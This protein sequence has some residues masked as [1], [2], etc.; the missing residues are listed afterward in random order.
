[1]QL[2]MVVFWSQSVNDG[3]DVHYHGGWGFQVPTQERLVTTLTCISLK[4]SEGVNPTQMWKQSLSTDSN[5]DGSLSLSSL[6]FWPWGH[7]EMSTQQI[8]SPDCGHD[9]TVA[10]PLVVSPPIHSPHISPADCQWTHS[11]T[12]EFTR[13][14]PGIQTRNPLA[15]VPGDGYGNMN[16]KWLDLWKLPVLL[17]QINVTYQLT[18][19]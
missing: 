7:S 15:L 14:V 19:D 17:L 9:A 13:S 16:I 1:M 5:A 18:S 6:V 3:C 12:I 11:S 2:E 8:L 4:V 10:G